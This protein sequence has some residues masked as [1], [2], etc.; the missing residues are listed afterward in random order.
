MLSIHDY[1][2]V[3]ILFI[4]PLTFYFQ[5]LLTITAVLQVLGTVYERLGSDSQFTVP[6]LCTLMNLYWNVVPAA[7]VTVVDHR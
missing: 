6:E 4:T 3:N 2:H 5:A 7:R 1:S